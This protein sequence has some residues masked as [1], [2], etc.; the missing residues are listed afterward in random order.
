MNMTRRDLLTLAGGSLLGAL[1][2]PVPWKLLDDSSI[3]TQNWALIPS[4]PRGP[5]TCTFTACALCP[6]GCALK[7]RRVNG[8]P[9]SLTGISGHP[10]SFGVL[11][12]AGIA[13]HHL[14]THPLRLGQPHIF[15]G[16]GPDST[17]VPA[18]LELA[19]SD[20]AK[21]I[22]EIQSSGARGTI[23]VLDHRPGRALSRCYQ[24]FLAK[25]PDGMY[26]I[27]PG[28]EDAT[29]GTLRSLCSLGNG[30]PGY[31]FEHTRVIL[32][33]GAP[34]LDG[35]G[36]PGRMTTLLQNRKHT[37]LKLIQAEGMQSRTALQADTWLPV[38]P[39]AE[40]ML[41][42]AIA[43]TI[44]REGRQHREAG[45]TFADFKVYKDVVARFHPDAVAEA[46]GISPETIVR[47]ARAIASAPSIIL[48]GSNPAG[49]P[50]DPATEVFI[51]GLN[52]LL[53]NIGR[54]GGIRLHR[55]TPSSTAP[56]LVARAL[57][58]VPD[59]SLRLLFVDAAESGST[60]PAALLKRKLRE[61]GTVVMMSPFLSPRTAL[62]D[63]VVPGP[64]AY[65]SLEEVSTPPGALR[66]SFALSI[67][68]MQG[69]GTSVD[70][71]AFL[72]QIA[73][74]AGLPQGET[75][76][77]EACLRRRAHEIWLARR[78]ALVGP[79]ADVS[80]PV[81]DLADQEELWKGLSEGACWIDDPGEA[82]EVSRF[83][84]LG[85]LH[86]D[87]ISTP[88]ANRPPLQLMPFG[89]RNATATASVAPVMSKLFQ[90][91]HLRN[92]GGQV[93]INPATLDASGLADGMPVTVTTPAGSMTALAVADPTV[94]PGIIHAAVGPSPNGTASNERPEAEDL[95]QLCAIRDDGS[96]R[97]TDAT[98]AKA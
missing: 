88:A 13:G 91:S 16:K 47:T 73:A 96:W 89:W 30:V 12:P 71:A 34:L 86:P 61:G 26:I 56:A 45:R 65:E 60:Y 78:G 52:I 5:E 51:A 1:F 43:N 55:D 53:G 31:D 72:A 94:L 19:V 25:C 67:P 42:L 59:R 23:A 11:C 40:A 46:C 79:S 93:H 74:A 84:L 7:A 38:R 76:T 54:E 85:T 9:V 82:E 98:I 2:T 18:S 15:S 32:S 68:L 83:S 20:I 27:A 95:L 24:D 77:T 4:L 14:A 3:W 41:A 10:V 57:A 29:L 17:L 64:A 63:Y 39:G 87:R 44:L 80:R 21:T 33:F 50:F 69:P 35:W 58:D 49:G 66:S 37:G 22:R 28:S 97:I 90:E 6:G 36:T 75:V 8:Y 81:R 92:L 70:P 48:S 62:A